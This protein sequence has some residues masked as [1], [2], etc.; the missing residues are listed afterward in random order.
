MTE[1]RVKFPFGAQDYQAPA[2]AASIT[3]AI[4]S[5]RT[6]IFMPAV[7]AMTLKLQADAELM[8]GSEVEVEIVQGG[9]ARNITLSSAGASTIIG[10]NLIGAINKTEGM[11]FFWDATN[12]K[13]VA[14]KTAWK[15][16]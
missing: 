9:T 10:A 2:D 15:S 7:Q 13:F 4:W 5:T 3:A 1:A 6:K 11:T 12:K 16:I 14:D 8:D